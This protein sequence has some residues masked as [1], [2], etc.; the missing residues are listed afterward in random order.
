MRDWRRE[1][2]RRDRCNKLVV[3]SRL[4]TTVSAFWRGGD[5]ALTHTL[6][7]VFMA[8]SNRLPGHGPL[9]AFSG[10][11]FA[12]LGITCCLLVVWIWMGL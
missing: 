9:V 2:A 6:V 10:R 3:L 12:A 1:P 4:A 8:L 5:R 7:A 11:S